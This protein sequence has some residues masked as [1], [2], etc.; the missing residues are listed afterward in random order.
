M[1]GALAPKGDLDGTW[2]VVEFRRDGVVLP[3]LATDETRWRY[4]TLFDRPEWRQ[5]IVTHMKG[6]NKRWLLLVKDGTLEFRERTVAVGDDPTKAPLVG[7]LAFTR[8]GEKTL[9]LAGEVAGARIEAVCERLEAKDFLLRNR[10]FHWV[11]EFP[12]NL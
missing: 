9:R 4:L 2:E 3:P 1:Y 6:V 8:D 10:G 5:A 7:T 11:N 12:F